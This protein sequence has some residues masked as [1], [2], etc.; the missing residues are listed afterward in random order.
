MM[1]LGSRKPKPADQQ[2][3]HNPAD[4][5]FRVAP[6]VVIQEPVV[7]EHLR[8]SIKV[9][10]MQWRTIK[11]GDLVVVEEFEDKYRYDSCM[12][13]CSKREYLGENVLRLSFWRVDQ[14]PWN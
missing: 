11:V 1:Y 5:K 7:V 8:L 12:A 10:A 2:K 14:H 3:K 9:D 6:Y 13:E 4:V